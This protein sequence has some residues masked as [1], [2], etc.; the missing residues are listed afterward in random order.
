MN[1][2]NKYVRGAVSVFLVMILVPC[3]LV[4]SIFVDLGRVYM[5]KSVSQ[6]TADLALNSL[7]TNYDADLSEWYGM[8]ASC[9]DIEQFYE[10]SAE[11]FLKTVTSQDLSAED[12]ATVSAYYAKMTDDDTIYDLLQMECLTDTSDMISEVEG[13]NLSNPTLIKD[14]IVEFMKYRAPIEIASSLISMFVN[15]DGTPTKQGDAIMNSKENNDLVEAK[16]DF[17]KS[18]GELL[19]KAY[20]SYLAISGYEQ[21]AKTSTPPL[22][23]ANLIDYANTI[24]S[25]KNIYRE[26]HTQS[27]LLLG[28]E[29]LTKF[30]RVHYDLDEY[31]YGK[32]DKEVYSSKKTEDGETI[33][34]ISDSKINS[35]LNTLESSIET[36]EKRKTAFENDTAI[37]TL[38][39]GY[40]SDKDRLL[41]SDVCEAQWWVQLNAAV[42]KKNDD[43]DEAADE[44]LD[45]Y[46]RVLA[47][48]KCEFSGSGPEGWKDRY[49][50]LTQ[51]VVE[52]NRKYLQESFVDNNSMYLR[53]VN[54]LETVSARNQSNRLSGDTKIEVDGTTKTIN[55]WLSEVAGDL[56]AI[57]TQMEDRINELTVAIDGNA[58]VFWGAPSL[59]S[60]ENE[61]RNYEKNFDIW[62]GEAS[63]N[64]TDLQKKDYIDINSEDLEL[65]EKITE[66]SVGELK[67]RLTNIRSQLQTLL[68]AVD[69]LKY[70]KEK[71]AKITTFDKFKA[72]LNSKLS[73][74]PLEE[75][76]IE[77]EAETSF[78]KL[79]KSTTVSLENTNNSEYNPELTTNT[80][81]LYSYLKKRFEA[82]GAEAFSKYND[83]EKE[84]EDAKDEYVEGEKTKA[85]EYRGN[86]SDI[87]PE[88]SSSKEDF[89]LTDIIGAVA[90]LVKDIVG[91]NYDNIRDDL[92]VA[93][94][95]TNM[96]SYATYDREMKYQLIKDSD[97]GDEK[98]K[99]I[100]PNNA[101]STEFYDNQD[102][103]KKFE[104]TKLTD[105][106]NKSLTNKMINADN[107]AAY[108]AEI[109]YIL[110]GQNTNAKNLKRS[111]GDIY[112]LRLALNTI[113]AFQHFW[114]N[115]FIV[116]TADLISGVTGGIIPAPVVKVVLLPIYAALET[117]MDNKRLS[118][119]MPV[120]I[121]KIDED[122]W[123]I[124]L[125]LFTDILANKEKYDSYTEITNYLNGD[126]NK[127]KNQDEGLFY[128]DYLTLFVYCGLSSGG[129]LEENMYK[130]IAEVIQ[131]NLAKKTG[132]SGYSLT[133][134]R[135]YFSLNATV[136][137]KP[138]MITLPIFNG[139]DKQ[140]MDTNYDWCTYDISLTRGYS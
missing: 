103:I 124:V 72:Q 80:P 77:S 91:S 136:R 55:Q 63:K 71:I 25:C 66:E 94:Y 29:S 132:D 47:I 109:E 49:D 38:M 75:S 22:T 54:A 50:E 13:A 60:L 111:F 85:E 139:Y 70:G 101:G 79:I 89:N 9:Q 51:K 28:T 34:Y 7:L 73:S 11:F 3:I 64:K 57:E 107:N 108:L 84:A 114:S 110:Y 86:G 56:L 128:S 6:S 90:G 52:L 21:K 95:V 116:A 53:I 44:M 18:E 92:Y 117:N 112:L 43:F 113:S 40:D 2:K 59:D 123:W 120:E 93:T 65:A 100:T 82:N 36:F 102:I 83:D 4:S 78:N 14:Q 122:D 133:K 135:M 96:F 125:P 104:S 118:Y 130:R 8:I 35:L 127:G 17:Y 1:S 27:A 119:G 69:D 106:Y 105:T 87:I 140:G 62:K 5:S 74:V 121:Y 138:L 41:N 98:I 33:Y 46:A 42:N 10:I 39:L 88:Y 67:T 20:K 12:L 32:N 115:D 58:F 23:N 126:A 97:G 37:K 30:T 31:S 99:G 68:D 24:N 45:Y 16:K 81:A 131:T 76:E 134:A 19:K 129:A 61:A 15:E 26:I 48:N 137:V